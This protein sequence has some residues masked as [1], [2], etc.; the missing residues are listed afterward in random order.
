MK[1]DIKKNMKQEESHVFYA[2]S[3]HHNYKI[4]ERGKGVYLYD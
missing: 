1:L 3:W 4:A 2:P